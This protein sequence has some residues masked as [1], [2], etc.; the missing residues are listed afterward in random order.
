MIITCDLSLP[1]LIKDDLHLLHYKEVS[2]ALSKGFFF[3]IKLYHIS[4]Q[5]VSLYYEV[6]SLS[7]PKCTFSM[8]KE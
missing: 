3:T 8:T 2:P 6:V 4:Y 1:L 5:S 7:L